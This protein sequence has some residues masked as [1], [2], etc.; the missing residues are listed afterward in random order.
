MLRSDGELIE[1]S[2]THNPEWFAATI[3][4]LGLTGLITEVTLQLRKIDGPW[5]AVETIPFASL[6]EFFELSAASEAL[7]EQ[8][9]AWIDCFSG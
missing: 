4:G 6:K 8:N 1:C 2:P 9:V 3:G 5:L 7:W